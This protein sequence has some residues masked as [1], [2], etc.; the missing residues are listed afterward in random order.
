M[1]EDIIE[2]GCPGLADTRPPLK[3]PAAIMRI[4]IILI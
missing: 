3:N 2:P 1:L 4:M